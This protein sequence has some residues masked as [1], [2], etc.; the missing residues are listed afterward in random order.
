MAEQGAPRRWLPLRLA[1]IGAVI[2]AAVLVALLAR[3]SGPGAGSVAIRTYAGL[4]ADVE[5]DL[6]DPEPG[7]RLAPGSGQI[8]VWTAGSSSCPW[9]PREVTAVGDRVTIVLRTSTGACT[10]DLAWS[11]S[12]VAVPDGVDLAGIEVEL[13][14]DG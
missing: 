11:T 4:P 8:A 7:W 6:L 5:A 13:V 10:A 9:V 3:P 2:V 12:V 14:L 1:V